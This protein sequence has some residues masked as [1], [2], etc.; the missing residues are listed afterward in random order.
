MSWQP[1][2][3]GQVRDH[4]LAL[5]LAVDVNTVVKG[6]YDV[7]IEPDVDGQP[8]PANRAVQL[9]FGGPPGDPWERC[10]TTPMQ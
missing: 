6:E 10:P 8:E 9:I 4:V 2:A 5:R 7:P 3:Y 1:G